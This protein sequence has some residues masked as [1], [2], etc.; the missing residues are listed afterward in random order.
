MGRDAFKASPI[1]LAPILASLICG[2]LC[3]YILK[4]SYIQPPQAV[5]FP[6]NP[7]GS[8][9]NALYFVILVSSGATIILILLKIRWG[10]LVTILKGAALAVAFFL[11][12]LVYLSAVFSLFSVFDFKVA[13]A[14]STFIAGIAC[15]II[16]K[17]R[18]RL[19]D[20]LIVI[21][22]GALG[23]FLGATIPALS[24]FLILLLLA[25]YDIF[26]V[27]R[28]AV[29]KIARDGIEHLRGLFLSFRDAQMGL[30]DLA[31]YSM[32]SGHMLMN[33]GLYPCL[34]SIVGILLGCF[35]TFKL[36]EKRS[37]F[38]GLPLPVAFG[39]SLGLLTS[40]F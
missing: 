26:A 2:F 10:K 30:G 14:A 18:S 23:A 33:F 11:L 19:G 37:I 24:A 6:D 7:S 1:Y 36:L 39:L 15:H 38:P 34:A 31:F 22:G 5:P 32:L 25:V 17:T 29:G 3:T 8:I 16:L 12:S 28:G 13:A 35:L 4:V 20:V 9:G 40:L 21:L 27:Y